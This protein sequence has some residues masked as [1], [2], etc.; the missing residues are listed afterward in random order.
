MCVCVEGERM[1]C[2]WMGEGSCVCVW[3]R[4]MVG[5]KEREGIVGIYYFTVQWVSAGGGGEDG[6]HLVLFRLFLSVWVVSWLWV[7]V[8]EPLV[9]SRFS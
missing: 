3:L 9:G 4:W 7:R 8:W 2:A 5:E 1:G 6:C